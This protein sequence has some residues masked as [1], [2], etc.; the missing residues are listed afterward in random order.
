MKETKETENMKI[1]GFENFEK[2]DNRYLKN[3]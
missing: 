1:R 2:F 3:W